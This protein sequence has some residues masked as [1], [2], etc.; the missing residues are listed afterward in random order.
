MRSSLS[1][2]MNRPRRTNVYLNIYELLSFDKYN[3]YLVPIGLGAYHSGV[4]VYG[5]EISFGYHEGDFSGIFSI[6]PR[7]APECKFVCVTSLS[8]RSSSER[9]FD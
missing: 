2:L 4:E 1:G 3:G 7:T 8:E 9:V 6:E 5:E